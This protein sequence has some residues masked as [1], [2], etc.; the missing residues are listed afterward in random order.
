M[1]HSSGAQVKQQYSS[2]STAILKTSVP[3]FQL[4]HL[5]HRI[6]SKE[7]S[8]T[9]A[10]HSVAPSSKSSVIRD[11]KHVLHF[12][13]VAFETVELCSLKAASALSQAV[14]TRQCPGFTHKAY[15]AADFCRFAPKPSAGYLW[16]QAQ[17]CQDGPN[18]LRFS[19][20]TSCC[21]TSLLYSA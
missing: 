8:N 21:L 12:C 13:S 4:S 16:R 20:L 5:L 17:H 19:L 7:A 9:H 14:H 18:C 10:L 1:K 15:T 2:G 6:M 11:I 3:L